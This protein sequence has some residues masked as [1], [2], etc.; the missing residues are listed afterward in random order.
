MADDCRSSTHYATLE[1]FRFSCGESVAAVPDVV[2]ALVRG[3]E[4]Q[5]CGHQL[6]DMVERAWPERAEERFQFGERQ[7]DRI[8]VGTVGWKKSQPRSGVLIVPRTSVVCE[9][10]DCRVRRRHPAA[11]STRTLARRTNER[12]VVDRAIEHGRGGQIGR[13]KRRDDGMRLP[14]SA[15][16]V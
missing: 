13:A 7:F 12:S 4:S 15:G 9:P 16:R 3:E 14:V 11:E 6:A 10:E 2:C 5:G 1:L 8:E